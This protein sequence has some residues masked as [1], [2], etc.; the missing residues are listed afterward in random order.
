MASPHNLDVS[1][2][3]QQAF[4]DMINSQRIGERP[5]PSLNK[6]DRIVECMSMDELEEF[7]AKEE[8]KDDMV[9]SP[10]IIDWNEME[11]LDGSISSNGDNSSDMDESITDDSNTNNECFLDETKRIRCEENDAVNLDEKIIEWFEKKKCP[12]FVASD[13][14]NLN[15]R[16]HGINRGASA[17]ALGAP[18][19]NEDE[20]FL[21]IINDWKHREP[22]IFIVR[23]SILPV[24]V[25]DNSVSN[26]HTE[27]SGFCNLATML[28]KNPPQIS[29]LDSNATIFS[30]R[31]IRD[32]SNMAIRRQIRGPGVAAGKSYSERMRRIFQD[33][34]GDQHK[35]IRGEKNQGQWESLKLVFQS[36]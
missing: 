12:F 27:A 20:D 31:T 22:I 4:E 24:R 11:S 13:G 21:S 14:G 9:A 17:V 33:W 28:Y 6:G 15:E 25:G 35:S 8:N 3:E 30:A 34:N 10:P 2:F 18:L 16:E 36:R 7:I 23:T 26:V 1:D 32:E 29:I 19:M 5:I